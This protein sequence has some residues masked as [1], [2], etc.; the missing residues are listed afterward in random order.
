[1]D[2]NWLDSLRASCRSGEPVRIVYLIR[3]FL[4]QGQQRGSGDNEFV[5]DFEEFE[6]TTRAVLEAVAKLDEDVKLVI[7][8]HPS[9]DFAVVDRLVSGWSSMEVEISGEPIYHWITRSDCMISLYS[10]AY[11]PAIAAGIPCI[12]LPT[13]A[14][15]FVES[16]NETM[17][18]MYLGLRGRVRSLEQLD[19]TLQQALNDPSFGEQDCDHLRNFYPDGAVYRSVARIDHL[20]SERAEHNSMS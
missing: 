12:V 15:E 9:N 13:E 10:T 1:M 2:R 8:P 16:Q 11:F 7:K 18:K 19:D 14:Q 6:V 3:R 20:V 5:M 4:N 17:S